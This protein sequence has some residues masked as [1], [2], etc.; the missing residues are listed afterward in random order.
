MALQGSSRE[1]QIWNKLYDTYKNAYGV[2]G[3]MGN[4]YAESGLNP[5]NLQNTFEN[6]LK[7]TDDSYTAA[8]DNGSYTNFVNDKAG[9]G[10]CQWTFY[11]RKQNML[12]WHRSR[13]KSIGD[14]ETQLDFLIHELSTSYQTVHLALMSATSVKSASDVVLH[15]FEKPRDQSASVEAKRAS[16]GQ[17]YYDKYAKIQASSTGGSN[18]SNSS[19]V[20]VTMLSPNHSGKRTKSI[21]RISPHCVV[22][23]LTAEGIGSCF[24]AGRQASCNYGIGKDGRVVLVVDEAN[25]SWCTSSNDND[26]QAVTIECASGTTEPYAFNDVVY[27]K[28]IDLCVDIC[29]RNGKKKLIWIA[30][31]N[32][33]LAYKPASTEMQITVH[34][35]FANKSCPGNWLMGKMTDLVAKVNQKLGSNSSTPSGSSN[36]SS[37]TGTSSAQNTL[38]A[39]P[40]TVNVIIDDLN[41]RASASSN[42]ASKG[43][44]G[45]GTF[46]ITQ[47]S[48]GWGKLKSGAGWIYLLNPAYCTIGKTTTAASSTVAKPAASKFPYSVRVDITDLRIRKGP[49]TNYAAN[50]YTGKGTFTITEESSGQGAKLWGK[51]KSGAGWIALDYTT[52]I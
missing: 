27:N 31:K 3:L 48:N 22:G 8:V 5:K 33:A 41:I 35:W 9:Y 16:Y 21:C 51:L 43:Y 18:M 39:A 40:F 6:S 2:A 20:N 1:E 11:S 36:V 45:K 17:P 24:P 38:P 4:I 50:G 7:M 42:A 13:G 34:R 30:D 44:T 12:N 52:K 10:L 32:T 25:R 37:N 15:N 29:K 28:L 26:Q 14:L 19:L 23:Q 49:G 47:V 46:T